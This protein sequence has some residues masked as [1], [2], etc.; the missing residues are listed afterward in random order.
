MHARELISGK[1]FE[2]HSKNK[3]H[4]SDEIKHFFLEETRNATENETSDPI[5]K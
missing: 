1:Y 4:T 3:S 5:V 2:I